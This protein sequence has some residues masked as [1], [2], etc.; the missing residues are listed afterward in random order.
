MRAWRRGRSVELFQ[1]TPAYLRQIEVTHCPVTRAELGGP[2]PGSEP[3]VD[4]VRDAAGYAAGNLALLSR[5]ANAA[6]GALDFAA[7]MQVV[8]RLE[9]RPLREVE[10][11]GAAAWRR[12]AVL[13]SFVEPL[14]HEAACTLPLQVLPPKRLHLMNPVQALQAQLSLQLMRPGWAERSRRFEALLAGA[15]LRRAYQPPCC[16]AGPRS[17]ASSTRR[18]ARPCWRG[19]MRSA[20]A[21]SAPRAS[22][23]R[24]RPRAG[25]STPPAS[26]RA[27]AGRVGGGLRPGLPADVTARAPGWALARP[28]PRIG[29]ACPAAAPPPPAGR[30]TARE[31]L[32]GRLRLRHLQCVLAVADTAHLGRAAERLCITQPAVTKTLNELEALLGQRLF[33]RSRQGTRVLEAAAPFLRHAREA[34]RALGAA[35]AARRARCGSARCRRWPRRC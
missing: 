27:L 9:D 12:I 19:W 18:A 26:T 5:R 28:L 17:H 20:S 3:S 30:R 24:R 23:R 15:P 8:R 2:V 14:P 31:A 4:R 6:K 25:S 29:H 34:L 11:L 7:A 10:G 33:E 35:R 22:P 21:R 32:A 1:V 13:C 16:C